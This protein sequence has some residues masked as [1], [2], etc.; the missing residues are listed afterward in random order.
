L[1]FH[2]LLHEHFKPADRELNNTGLQARSS[3]SL[4]QW[5]RMGSGR[6]VDAGREKPRPLA[7]CLRARGPQPATA[8]AASALRAL[9][10]VQ[11]YSLW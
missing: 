8:R 7:T 10:Q 5:V 4:K 11:A 6:L 1:K 3:L 2:Q 9:A